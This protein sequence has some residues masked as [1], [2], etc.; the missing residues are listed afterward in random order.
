M[1]DAPIVWMNGELVAADEVRVSPF[2]LGLAVGWGVFETMPSYEG[3]VFGFLRHYGRLKYSSS[4]LGIAVPS[5]EGLKKAVDEVI[6][7]NGFGSGRARVRL[8]LSGGENPLVG[9]GAGT[10]ARG[11]VMVTAVEI[12]ACPTTPVAKLVAVP[13][14]H[15]EESGLSG[16]KTSSYGNHLRA[17]RA[18]VAAGADEAVMT[19]TTGA[20]CEG[21]MSNLFIVKEGGVKTPSLESG[22]LPGVTRAVVLELC[23]EHGIAAEEGHMTMAEVEAADEVFLT[24]SI[25]EVQAACFHGADCD[26]GGEVTRLLAGWYQERIREELGR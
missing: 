17:L 22:C 10:C 23:R 14:S 7:A 4:V 24:S 3:E 25:R 1:S 5:A 18:A 16:C 8:S 26:A 9:T 20:V 12:P 19:N 21:A 15:N 13:F 11:Y 6:R 2:D